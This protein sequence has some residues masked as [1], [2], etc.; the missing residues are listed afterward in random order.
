M[1]VAFLF[2]SGISRKAG[3]KNVSEITNIIF[4]GEGISRYTDSEYYFAPPLY[5]HIDI[6]EDDNVKRIVN[7]LNILKKYNND[8]FKSTKHEHE[9]N[10]EDIYFIVDQLDNEIYGESK[11][12][13]IRE[14]LNKI[15]SHHDL[16]L[17][18]SHR[19]F[20]SDLRFNELISET[21]TY[22][23][24]IV[25]KLLYQPIEDIS[26]LNIF[27]EIHDDKDF[28][29]INFFTLNHDILLEKYFDENGLAFYDG[30]D[31]KDGDFAIFN[32]SLFEN[33]KRVNLIKLHGSVDWKRYREDG[34]DWRGDYIAKY[35]V[36]M[37][38]DPKDEKGRIIHSIENKSK[39]LIGTENKLIEYNYELFFDLMCFFKQKLNESNYLIISGYGFRDKGINAKILNWFY[40]NDSNKII[41]IH[42]HAVKLKEF[43]S[44][45]VGSKMGNWIQEK[46]MFVLK[47]WFEE[48]SWEEIKTYLD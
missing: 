37:G 32:S 48:V 7:F 42:K 45:A 4:S 19:P 25:A 9:T 31:I 47:K 26:Y 14:Y 6:K 13:F 8:Y 30:F 40:N 18:A 33:Q 38:I 28:E 12:V 16:V 15:E 21:L 1:N 43:A 35:D 27:K 34:K 44:G 22:L 29:Q 2:G 23:S 36:K 20:Y 46:R 39:I 10:Y 5:S 17:K 3:F 41:L 24:N 11:N